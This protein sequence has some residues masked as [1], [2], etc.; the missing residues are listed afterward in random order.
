MPCFSSVAALQTAAVIRP[1]HPLLAV[2]TCPY[3][4][5][6]MPPPPLLKRVVVDKTKRERTIKDESTSF[7]QG[8]GSPSKGPYPIRKRQRRMS[9]MM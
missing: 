5:Q 6:S 7:D 2:S 8:M 1:L 4:H 9:S 3:R